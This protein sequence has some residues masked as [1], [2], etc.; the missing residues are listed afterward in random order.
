MEDRDIQTVGERQKEESL[1][2][3][4]PSV[5]SFP[6]FFLLGQALGRFSAFVMPSNLWVLRIY[7]NKTM[8]KYLLDSLA[9]LM[10]R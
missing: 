8:E 9:W 7:I 4:S 3:S 1:T 5:F 6:V 2:Y 10:G